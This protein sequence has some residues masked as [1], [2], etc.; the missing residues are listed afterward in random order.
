M[1]WKW[2]STQP[3]DICSRANE[4]ES[5]GRRATLVKVIREDPSEEVTFE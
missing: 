2:D 3:L 1:W 4:A 5:E